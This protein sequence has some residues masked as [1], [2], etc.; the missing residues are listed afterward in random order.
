M[1]DPVNQPSQR[2]APD[3]LTPTPPFKKEGL[4]PRT[5]DAVA[6]HYRKQFQP[7]LQADYAA[8]R[9]A[10][11]DRQQY[12]GPP[13][14]DVLDISLCFDGTNNHEPSDKR[15]SP[16]STS[17]VARLYHASLGPENNAANNAM[18]D[19]GFYRYYV[20]GVGTEF[21]EI[22]EFEPDESG[23]KTAVGGE[24]R[25]NWGLTRLLDAVGRACGRVADGP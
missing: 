24:N 25:I 5:P 12:V 9:Q 18:S 13:C 19:E 4:L 14:I 22:G 11:E 6:A 16:P 21:K 23:L 8:E 1:S 10:A 20:Q 2:P 17:N 7:K 3:A 15:G